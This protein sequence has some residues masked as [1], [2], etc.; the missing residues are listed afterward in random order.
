MGQVERVWLESALVGLDLSEVSEGLVDWLPRLRGLG[1]RKVYLMH[2]LPVEITEYMIGGIPVVRLPDDL[3]GMAKK[4]LRGYAERL[5]GEG[6]EAEV[7]EPQ[8]GSPGMLLAQKAREKGA[9]F[10]IVASRGHGMLRLILLGSTTEETINSSD[11]PVLVVRVTKEAGKV[12]VAPD[13]SGGPVIAAVT[14]DG[15]TADVALRAGDIAR[16]LGS[17]VILAHVVEEGESDAEA[18][19]LLDGLAR[20][21]EANG[22][23]VEQ[24]IL[25]GRPEKAIL[26]L[27]A[28]TK[29]PLIVTGKTSKSSKSMGPVAEQIVRRSPAHVLVVIK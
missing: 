7:V 6:L 25:R 23:K 29:A 18:R 17:T 14:R 16:S 8:F 11:R 21:L 13:I 5:R 19:D 15:Y 3:A 24:R 27:A 9:G 1:V 4:V 12:K 22:V 26:K 28:D 10:I 20:Q 2:V